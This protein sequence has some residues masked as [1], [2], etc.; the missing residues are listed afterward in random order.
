MTIA[1]VLLAYAVGVATLGARMLARASWTARAPLLAILTYLAAA[2]SVVAALG[3]VGL[4]LAVHATALGGAL[5][6][7]IGACVLRLR[8]TY[9]TPGG[10]AVAGAGLILAGTVAVR[11]ALTA[12]SHL[13]LRAAA[14]A[15]V[16]G[17]LAMALTP[18]VLALGLGRVPHA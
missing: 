17:P 16:L 6:Q 18:A 11:T 13:L 4:I 3:L 9:A 14:A 12:A 10:A 7:L 5:S 2:W 1:A 15:L 8:A